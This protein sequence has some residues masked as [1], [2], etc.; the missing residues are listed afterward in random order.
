MLLFPLPPLRAQL[1]SD[2]V[3]LKAPLPPKCQTQNDQWSIQYSLCIST[4]T[5]GRKLLFIPTAYVNVP[6]FHNCLA[7]CSPAIFFFDFAH[8]PN[9]IIP[10]LCDRL[11]TEQTVSASHVSRGSYIN[12]TANEYLLHCYV[13]TIQAPKAWCAK[14]QS[15]SRALEE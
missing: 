3:S 10:E 4:L 14:C 2:V 1:C 13:S 7:Q 9:Y 12:M 8:S 5:K 6:R 15:C 11:V